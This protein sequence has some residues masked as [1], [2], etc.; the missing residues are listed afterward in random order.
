MY[1]RN[2]G[3]SLLDTT[4][5]VVGVCDA[6]ISILHFSVRWFVVTRRTVWIIW[7]QSGAGYNTDVPSAPD[8]GGARGKRVFPRSFQSGLAKQLS[9]LGSGFWSATTRG[10]N[11]VI[12]RIPCRCPLGGA[13]GPPPRCTVEDSLA[14]AMHEVLSRK[15][16]ARPGTAEAARP[17]ARDHVATAR[18]Q[19]RAVS[20]TATVVRR[21]GAAGCSVHVRRWDSWPLSLSFFFS[22]LFSPSLYLVPVY[23]GGLSNSTARSATVAT[24]PRAHA[25]ARDV[26]TIVR[27]ERTRAKR[28]LRFCERKRDRFRLGPPG[29]T[30]RFH[31]QARG[32][33]SKLSVS[34]WVE[35]H[36][37]FRPS[38]KRARWSLNVPRPCAAPSLTA[39]LAAHR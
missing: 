6:T 16:R 35:N 30:G 29:P 25:R 22:L 9:A 24:F 3:W 13:P 23:R 19:K 38:R 37:H 20:V 36:S 33:P 32:R 5:E 17:R 4:Q 10:P 15:G 34:R 11:E 28:A 31:E 39:L 12:P 7:R 18:W 1:S 8:C 27:S 14:A 21:G 26:K 2:V